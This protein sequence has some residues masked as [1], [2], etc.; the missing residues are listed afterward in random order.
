[1]KLL[2]ATALLLVSAT[3][4]GQVM[5]CVS[6]DG[7]VEYASRCPAGTE[8]HQTT[9]SNK[10][11]G[12]K[13]SPAAPS[14]AAQK[15]I[16]EQN[17]AYNKR[18]TEKRESEQKAQKLAAEQAQKN[19]ACDSARNYL[20]LLE[21]GERLRARDPKTGQIGY[22]DDAG[23]QAEIAKAQKGVADNCQ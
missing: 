3:A 7:R 5:K 19:Q 16:A 22:I 18:Q 23:R 4:Y 11:A 2:T 10:A 21:S 14:A 17:A 6:S 8:E 13:S 9:I 15:S 1:M 20:K 12:G